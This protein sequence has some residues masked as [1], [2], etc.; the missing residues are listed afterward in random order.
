LGDHIFGVD[1]NGDQGA[2]CDALKFCQLVS[3]Q[4]DS[5]EKLL[6][7]EVNVLGKL[8][9]FD[10]SFGFCCPVNL[11]SVEDALATVFQDPVIALPIV[12][13]VN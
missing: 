1:V 13:L 2:H 3:D 12:V 11:R 4:F 10:G 7:E 6:I 8:L 9:F 5:S